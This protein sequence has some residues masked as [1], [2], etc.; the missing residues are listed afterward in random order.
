[1]DCCSWKRLQKK[2]TGDEILERIWKEK[3]KKRR[4]E[5]AFRCN[6]C[7]A[8]LCLVSS[9]NLCYLFNLI[10]FLTLHLI[11]SL[12]L[13]WYHLIFCQ[14]Y[15]TV[16]NSTFF[17]SNL[18]YSGQLINYWCTSTIRILIYSYTIPIIPAWLLFLFLFSLSLL[19]TFSISL[20]W[21]LSRTKR[22]TP[23]NRTTES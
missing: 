7:A 3:H 15:S 23:S 16:L 12:T 17:I 13:I 14:L 20:N 22:F 10:H 4:K 8:V 6:T 2:F 5:K 18:H 1:M 11:S 9:L 19:F 21:K